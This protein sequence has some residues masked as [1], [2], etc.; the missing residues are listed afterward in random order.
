[1]AMAADNQVHLDV[2]GI[3]KSFGATRAL[4]DVSIPIRSGSVH[5]FVGENG[6]G[7]S[8][9]GKIIAGVF[10]QDQGDLVLRGASVAFGSPREALQRGIALVAQEVALVP[11]LRVAENVFLG[12]E[13]RRTGFIDRDRLAERF[14]V[15]TTDAGF[16]L[17]G[18][19]IVGGLPIAQ[20]QQVEILRALARDAD[21]IVLD[22]PSASLSA[23]EVE[24]LHEIVRRLRAGG[25]TVILV[26]HLLLEVLE[27][28]DTVTVL[29]DGKVVRTGP[30][31]DETEDSLVAAMLGRPAS[32]TY[33]DKRL[34]PDDSPVALEIR[35]LS[36]PGVRDVSMTV[37]AGEIVGLAGLIG[38]GRSEL[39]RA[40]YGAVPAI[41]GEVHAGTTALADS[42]V[43]SIH[44][45]VA[46]IPESRKDEGLFLRRP[47]REN[48]SLGN[49]AGLNRLGFVRRRAERV[50]VAGVL[51]RVAGSSLLE[52]PAGSLSGGNQQ[53][54]LFAR[55]LLATPSVLIADEPTRGVDVGAKRDL[56]ELLVELAAGGL[57]ILLISNEMEE[58]LGLA[59]RVVVM[60]KGRVAAELAGP[61]MTE[62]GILAAAFGTGGTAAA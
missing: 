25:R 35:N 28:A 42:P 41:G 55:A 60:R 11:Q 57:A 49:L 46:L 10:P 43:G 59:H 31:S 45:G 4:D 47:V 2:R 9:L 34:P 48:V 8:T 61:A 6:A 21:L 30:A 1:M 24:R 52:A 16:D 19:A 32:R 39:A 38:A 36:A 17:D 53:K 15:L 22:E 26:S 33:P 27:L 37:R 13:P 29:R 20:Q 18:N 51:A 56:Y 3:G 62:A 23:H 5:A 54:L 7:K 50:E 14:Q 44:A 58:L 40:V 12:A